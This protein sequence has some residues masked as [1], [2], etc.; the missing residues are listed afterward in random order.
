MSDRFGTLVF[1]RYDSQRLPGKALLSVGGMPLL[2]RVIRRA[3]LLP[4]PV[5][6][7]TTAKPSDDPLVALAARLGVASFRGSEDRVLERAVLAAEWF[8]LSA[9]A[10][11]CGDRPLFPLD[12]LREA[13]AI[14]GKDSG[15]GPSVSAPD[16]VTNR[17]SG[18]CTPG[19]TTEVIRTASLRWILDRGLSALQQEH[20]TSY[21]YE[22]PHDFAIIELPSRVVTYSCP[23]FAVDTAADLARLDRIF[24]VTA[25][26]D[27]SAAEADRI[28]AS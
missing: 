27:L 19:L 16:L 28:L 2:E 20:L 9:F 7:A 18:D 8:G 22:H 3:R 11:V 12:E 17:L 5:Y 1:A 6:L 26:L 15:P 21:L 10:R 24:A 25:A 4:W 14:M 13:A 23:G